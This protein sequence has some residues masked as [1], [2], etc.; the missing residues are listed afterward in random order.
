M[1]RG[2]ILTKNIKRL[3][4]LFENAPDIFPAKHMIFATIPFLKF[5]LKHAEYVTL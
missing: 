3:L 4:L 1:R 2:T 5:L